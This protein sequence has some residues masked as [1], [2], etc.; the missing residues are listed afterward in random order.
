MSLASQDWAE[1]GCN[2]TRSIMELSC[3]GWIFSSCSHQDL[4]PEDPGGQAE[5][6][7]VET[8]QSSGVLLAPS[9]G[10]HGTA[11]P[12]ALC[13]AELGHPWHCNPKRAGAEPFSGRQAPALWAMRGCPAC[14]LEPSQAAVSHRGWP[15][16]HSHTV[17]SLPAA[18]NWL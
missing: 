3:W 7:L 11:P 13:R 12:Q 9:H 18:A 2:D 16:S 8:V 14:D 6:L 1:R 4:G 15:C 10:P 17:L 5:V